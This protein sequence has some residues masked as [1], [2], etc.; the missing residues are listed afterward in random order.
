VSVGVLLGDINESGAV[1]AQDV[2]ITRNAVGLDTTSSG[3]N[4]NT[5][6]NESGAVN[7]QDV[8]VVRNAVGN[9]IP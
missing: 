7:A 3:F 8:T 9:S 4:P 5:D 2:T 1:N 6:V